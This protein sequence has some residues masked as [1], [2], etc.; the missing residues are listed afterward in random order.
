MSDQ[1]NSRNEGE[2][3]GEWLA[4]LGAEPYLT[5]QD[6]ESGLA[7]N[8]VMKEIVEGYRLELLTANSAVNRVSN[9]N[10]IM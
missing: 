8:F 6:L 9:W 5:H 2:N 3:L 7:V 1:V 4:Q 10:N